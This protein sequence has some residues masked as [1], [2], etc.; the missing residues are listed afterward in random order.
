MPGD[1]LHWQTVYTRKIVDFNSGPLTTNVPA[2]VPVKSPN[3]FLIIQKIIFSPTVY[4]TQN[5]IFQES[6][7]LFGIALFS[8]PAVPPSS[9]STGSVLYNA[10]FGLTGTALAIGNSLDLVSTGPGPTGRIHI[11]AYERLASGVAFVEGIQHSG[12]PQGLIQ[13]PG[14]QS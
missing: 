10:D 6:L 14:S 1:Y 2:I 3:H 9:G 11:E 7:T 8:I 4:V 5:L 12:V 13:T